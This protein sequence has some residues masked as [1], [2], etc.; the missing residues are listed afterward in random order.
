MS[1]SEYIWGRDVAYVSG[2]VS[3]TVFKD[4]GRAGAD[5]YLFGDIHFSY[6]STCTPLLGSKV[7]TLNEL[8]QSTLAHPGRSTRMLLEFPYATDALLN[9]DRLNWYYR[10]LQERL[11]SNASASSHVTTLLHRVFGVPGPVVGTLSKLWNSF[12]DSDH[13]VVCGDI[14][15]EPNVHAWDRALRFAPDRARVIASLF[16]EDIGAG[17]RTWLLSFATSDSF[18]SRARALFKGSPV[19]AY[20]TGK[21]LVAR[22]GQN[23]ARGAKVHEIRAQFL[24]L[25]THDRRAV[26]AFMGSLADKMRAVY[27]TVREDYLATHDDHNATLFVQS[28]Q[29]MLMDVYMITNMLQSLRKGADVLLVH[30]GHYHSQHYVEFFRTYCGRKPAFRH[31]MTQTRAGVSRCISVASR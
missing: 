13:R 7:V 9:D 4:V 19:A 2:P 18:L 6:R 27:T 24:L 30:T 21:T 17:L 11:Q 22:P 23:N 1:H 14:R 28:S 20:F 3:L 16:D 31:P 15:S 8:F 12:P 26:R 25:N 10:R 29:A 5:V